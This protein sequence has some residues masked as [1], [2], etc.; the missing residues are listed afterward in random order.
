MGNYTLLEYWF[1]SVALFGWLFRSPSLKRFPVR[2]YVSV[3]VPFSMACMPKPTTTRTHIL[4]KSPYVGI[5]AA[6]SESLR[7]LFYFQFLRINYEKPIRLRA[8]HVVLPPTVCLWPEHFQ[9]KRM[10]IFILDSDAWPFGLDDYL[11]IRRVAESSGPKTS[12]D[13]AGW[14]CKVSNRLNC[15]DIKQVRKQFP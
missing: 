14:L 11:Q 1:S 7:F 3:L 5:T 15:N 12:L 4:R 6:E 13:M 9:N 8:T 2:F 10:K